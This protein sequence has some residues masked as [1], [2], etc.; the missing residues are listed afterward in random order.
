MSLDSLNGS[1][2]RDRLRP[3]LSI[4]GV[5][6]QNKLEREFGLRKKGSRG[7]VQGIISTSIPTCQITK[8]YQLPIQDT[9]LKLTEQ[10]EREKCSIHT[11]QHLCIFT[12]SPILYPNTLSFITG[13]VS[14]NTHHC[15]ITTTIL[16]HWHWMCEPQKQKT[17]HCPFTFT[18][19]HLN[20]SCAWKVYTNP[21]Y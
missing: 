18:L 20:S 21:E 2:F 17:E 12:L 10:P 13:T 5:L 1:H 19:L 11:K 9:V 14:F 15:Y 4:L 7:C 8:N 3:L 6:S 16:K